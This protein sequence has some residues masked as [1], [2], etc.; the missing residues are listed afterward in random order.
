MVS[1]IEKMC[2]LVQIKMTVQRRIIAEVISKATDHPDA[3]E[4]HKRAH[5][6]DNKISLATV[7]RTISIFEYH[8]LI[9]KLEIGGE[10]ARYEVNNTSMMHHHHLIDVE[11]REIIEFTDNEI[12]QLKE[13]IA[14]RLGYKLVHHRLELYGEKIKK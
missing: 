4:I 7:Y 2:Q 12:E 14:K 5:L 6:I 3:D 1:R 11:T 13:K 9:N 8:N 10:K